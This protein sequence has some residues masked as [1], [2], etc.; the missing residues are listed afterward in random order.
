MISSTSSIK[1]PDLLYQLNSS[2]WK[3]RNKESKL[4]PKLITD[5]TNKTDDKQKK[6]HL[7]KKQKR[8]RFED[9]TVEPFE[10]T[11]NRIYCNDSVP[12]VVIM[13]KNII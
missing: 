8:R 10:K 12:R 4:K 1:G 5:R 11:L 9:K 6:E 3:Q 7:K 13:N 2:Q